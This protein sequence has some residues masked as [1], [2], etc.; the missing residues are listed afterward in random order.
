MELHLLPLTFKQ[1]SLFIKVTFLLEGISAFF[2]SSFR[3]GKQA[4]ATEMAEIN[5]HADFV[6]PKS[7]VF[8]VVIAV[9]RSSIVQNPL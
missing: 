9:L 7:L 1:I 5:A 4:G 2:C 8:T 3:N 6:L